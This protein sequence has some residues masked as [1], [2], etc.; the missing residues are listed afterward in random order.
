MC[1]KYN[2][3]PQIDT[4]AHRLSGCKHPQLSGM[5]TI[6]HNS[7]AQV[8]VKAIMRGYKGYDQIYNKNLDDTGQSKDNIDILVDMGKDVNGKWKS[9]SKTNTRLP[10]HR[11][12]KS[13]TQVQQA[14]HSKNI[15]K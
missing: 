13:D 4:P 7:L 8:I 10:Y 2:K 1:E 6:R 12:R 9:T 14:R 5:Y 15:I 11:P 3:I